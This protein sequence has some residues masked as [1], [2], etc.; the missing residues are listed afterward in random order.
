[1]VPWV[2]LLLPLPALSAVDKTHGVP[3][4]LA[5]SY[6]PTTKS[7][8]QHT[9]TCLDGSK[10]I[11]WSAVND[12]YC[13]CPDGSDEPGTGACPDTKFYCRNEGHI[14]AF[15]PSSRVGDGLCGMLRIS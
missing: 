5:A 15:I 3:P 4:T 12:D 8:S 10:V 7:A 11:S 1:M 13:D 14:G 6:V 9:W 2:L